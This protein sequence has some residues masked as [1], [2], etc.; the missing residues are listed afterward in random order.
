[1]T[2][3]ACYRTLDL[4]PGAP[5]PEIKRAYRR[6]ARRWHPDRYPDQPTRQQVAGER[7]KAI[8]AAY[9]RL[10]AASPQERA[11]LKSRPA[12]MGASAQRSGTDAARGSDR[13]A[14]AHRSR[15]GCPRGARHRKATQAGSAGRGGVTVTIGDGAGASHRADTSSLE[16][17]VGAPKH[18]TWL[19]GG[20]GIALVAGAVGVFC[21]G[22]LRSATLA[23]MLAWAAVWAVIAVG[24]FGALPQEG[25]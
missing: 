1:M 2:L 16:E 24:A 21:L 17:E 13:S 4:A 8:C 12:L 22:V 20:R 23:Q 14:V 18:G 19:E 15:R 6:L 5:L 10:Q 3:R 7:F 25:R 11:A 9:E